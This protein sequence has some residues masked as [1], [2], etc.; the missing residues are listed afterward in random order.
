MLETWT[1]LFSVTQN[2]LPANATRLYIDIFS[3]TL[4]LSLLFD[5][6]SYRILLASY[7]EM[8]SLVFS[9]HAKFFSLVFFSVGP[10]SFY[11]HHLIAN[12]FCWAKYSQETFKHTLI[13]LSNHLPFFCLHLEE[14]KRKLTFSKR[15]ACPIF[16]FLN[17][18]LSLYVPGILCHYSSRKRN[19]KECLYE[20][21]FLEISS[22]SVCLFLLNI[23]LWPFS[24]I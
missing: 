7:Y 22:T 17:K 14:V 9:H 5:I 23:L 19:L 11:F 13:P 2:S 18:D 20:I 1:C 24:V 3:R 6:S 12:T 4:T 8:L 15:K 10:N 16:S 21:S